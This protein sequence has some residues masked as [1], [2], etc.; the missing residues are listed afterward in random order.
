MLLII[1]IMLLVVSTDIELCKIYAENIIVYSPFWL[2]SLINA[3]NPVIME[4][5]QF[6]QMIPKRYLL[7]WFDWHV[8]LLIN[9]M[10]T[11]ESNVY[12]KLLIS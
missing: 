6:K 8:S 12:H 4:D 5:K 9:R 2:T 11:D 7:D 1:S 3:E 10:F